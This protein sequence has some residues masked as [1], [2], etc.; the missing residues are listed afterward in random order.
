[1]KQMMRTLSTLA[2]AS[3]VACAGCAGPAADVENVP[4]GA[5]VELIRQDGG[6][7][8]GTLAARDEGTVKVEAGAT[9]RSI[10]RNEIAEVRVVDPVKPTPLPAVAKFRELTL[11]QGTKLAVRLGSAVGSDTSRVEDPVEATVSEAVVVDGIDVFPVGS[12]VKGEVAAVQAAGKV[13]GRASLALRFTSITVAGRDEPS[14]IVARTSL[15]APSTTRED[16]AK[17]GIPAAG[18]AIVGGI[19]GGK[20]GAA[21]GT[22][23]GG[24]AGTAVVLSTSGDEIRLARGAALTLT[25]ERAIDVRV[26]ITRSN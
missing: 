12:V 22:A 21:I 25:I 10:P 7:V 20:K 11:P 2:L 17:I 6:V 14:E 24:G 26:P 4:V 1:M 13:K 15:E 23:V 19:I 5:D 9:S 18:G 3:V 16:A 8:R